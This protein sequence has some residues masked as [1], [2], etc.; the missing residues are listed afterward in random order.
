MASLSGNRY[1]LHMRAGYCMD[2]ERYLL[3]D[4][5]QLPQVHDG[6]LAGL[7]VTGGTL[8]LHIDDLHEPNAPSGSCDMVFE[9][10]DDVYSDVNLLVTRF[11]VGMNVTGR[12]F[13]LDDLMVYME[14]RRLPDLWV[15][16]ILAR[17]EKVMIGCWLSALDPEDRGS[18]A[19]LSICARSLRYLWS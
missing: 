13:Y 15:L 8:T 16:E 5:T 1:V 18:P 12:L 19:W 14:R 6:R 4:V 17:C 3:R 11:G 9:G 10:F 7:D 2:E